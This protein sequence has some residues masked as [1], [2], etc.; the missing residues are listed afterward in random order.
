MAVLFL[1]CIGRTAGNVAIAGGELT[2]VPAGVAWNEPTPY[3]M[4][5]GKRGSVKMGPDK[6]ASLWGI[7]T[8]QRE[9][10]VESFW[11]DETEVTVAEYKQ[12]IYWVRD[13]IIR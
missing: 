2:G 1:S 9:I 4:T 12:F 7:Q 10:S 13:S 11:M 5:L 6:Q 8:P 3:G